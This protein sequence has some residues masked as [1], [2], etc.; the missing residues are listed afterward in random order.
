VAE[1]G[2]LCGGTHPDLVMAWRATQ[3]QLGADIVASVLNQLGY[4][5]LIF[6][7]ASLACSPL[8]TIAGWNWGVRIRR[9]LGLFTF[10]YATLHFLTYF[11]VDQSLAL[12]TVVDDIL[13]RNFILVGFLAFVIM[14][15]LAITSTNGMVR[16]IGFARWKWLH[17][18]A[19]L[20]GCLGVV[21][22]IWRVKT[23]YREPI[24]FGVIVGVGLLIR[25]VD[26][27][28]ARSKQKK[29]SRSQ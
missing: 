17:R 4:L 9:M 8:N 10:F 11:V 2:C 3:G 13:K 25:G 19:Y 5:T 27:V 23:D 26:A 6:L 7:A 1:T 29:R 22:F 28:R 12:G 21:H 16:R 15:P 24:I 18:T 20:V 14:I